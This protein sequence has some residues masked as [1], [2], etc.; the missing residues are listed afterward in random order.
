MLNHEIHYR[1]NNNFETSFFDETREVVYIK[2][3]TENTPTY[4]IQLPDVIQL[5]EHNFFVNLW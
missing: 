5:N 1:S 3:N 4:K 2:Y